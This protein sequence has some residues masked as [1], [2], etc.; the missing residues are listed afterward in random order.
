MA[1]GSLFTV[2]VNFLFIK[3]HTVTSSCFIVCCPRAQNYQA[4]DRPNSDKIRKTH[5]QDHLDYLARQKMCNIL[6][7]A[8][9]SHHAFDSQGRQTIL[10]Q[11]VLNVNSREEASTF[12]HDDPFSQNK[13]RALQ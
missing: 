4:H 13:V 9:A 5:L 6:V 7:M 11:F 12:I 3:P 2:Q 8:S 1:C 10:S